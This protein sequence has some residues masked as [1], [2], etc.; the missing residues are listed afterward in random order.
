MNKKW[1]ILIL[2]MIFL[3]VGCGQGNED[4]NA[5]N[6]EGNDKE[7]EDKETATYGG[8]LKVAFDAQ[9]VTLDQQT[10]AGTP[11]RDAA[12]LM[13]ETLVTVNS[14]YEPVPML[15][16]SVD[17]SDDSKVYTFHLREGVT[18]HNGNEMTAEDVISSM[19]RWV[20]KSPVT[21]NIFEGV[22]FTAQDDYTVVME[23]AEPSTL[24]LDTMA[25]AKQAA[26]IM[27]KEV[28]ESAAPEG[29]TEYIGTGPFKFVEWKQDQ[30]MHF[31]KYDDYQMVDA[32]P[33]GLAGKK[34]ALVDDIY[35]HF[36]PDASTRMAG[37]QSGEYDIAY[38]LPYDM[39]EQIESNEDLNSYLDPYGE[40][41]L[42]YNKN[43]GLASNADIRRA[44][45]TGLDTD[46]MMMAAFSNEDF[47]WLDSGY[48]HKNISNWASDAGSEFYNQKDQE[49]AKQML[50][51]AGYNGEQFRIMTTRDVDLIYNGAVVLQQQLT[52]IGINAKL[53]IYDWPTFSDKMNNQEEW[54]AFVVGSSIVSTPSQLIAI[55]AH[56]AGGV[57]DSK[58]TEGLRDIETSASQEEA[59]ALWD[60]LQRY[61]WEEHM[62]ISM[63]GGFN[64][65]Y[66]ATNKVEGLQTF[67]GVIYWNMYKTE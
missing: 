60:E 1:F 15:A 56:Y 64:D 34:E 48:M 18:F 61:A 3:L 24:A 55:S 40:Y 17:V 39:Y 6:N 5:G 53:D 7:S 31:T 20:E 16:E 2:S 67:S 32:D 59:K 23:L 27:P 42:M 44:I 65:L 46:A 4:S 12:R 21:G 45:N 13:F 38:R 50:E 9:P 54:D 29:V 58:I 47:Y 11:T 62:P 36:V 14:K 10:E 43:A 49:K 63:L 41:V 51:D 52:D 30:Y 33:D 35:I 19:E 28:I 37:I 66:G 57:N 22:T 25:T 26:A 8:E